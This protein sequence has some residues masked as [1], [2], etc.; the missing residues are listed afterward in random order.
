MTTKDSVL[1]LSGFSRFLSC[2]RTEGHIKEELGQ[3]GMPV[4]FPPIRSPAEDGK[5]FESLSVS[6][7]AIF[8]FSVINFSFLVLVKKCLKVLVRQF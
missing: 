1:K 7:L 2:A 6:F 8:S 4:T 3:N 5:I